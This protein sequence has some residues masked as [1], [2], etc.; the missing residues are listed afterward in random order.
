MHPAER[1]TAPASIETG[2]PLKLLLNRRAVALIA[3]SFVDAVPGFARSTF[4]RQANA[5]LDDLELKPRAAHIAHVL[6]THLSSDPA[7]AAQQLIASLGPELSM[8][9]GNG[10]KPFFYLPHS[11]FIHAHLRDWDAGMAANEAITR[12]FSA[13]FS[14]RPF[15]IREQARTL[16]HLRTWTT[17]PNA[18]VRRLVSEGT[19]PRLPWAERLPGLVRDPTP[20]LPLLDVLVDDVDLY[21]RRSVANHIGDIAKDHP[22]VAFAQCARWLRK[23]TRERCW[24]VRH[25]VRHPAKHG[26]TEAIDLRKKAGGR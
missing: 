10:L 3:E 16:K 23:P 5:G 6:A 8:S 14:I 17:H 15:L 21:V 9:A 18:H 26:I 24:V 13:E 20:V 12:R 11:A 2:T 22:A 1:F 4:V 7:T 25:A 19:R